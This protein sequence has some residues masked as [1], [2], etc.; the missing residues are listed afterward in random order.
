MI[1]VSRSVIAIATM[2]VIVIMVVMMYGIDTVIVMMLLVQSP[3][4]TKYHPF[5]NLFRSQAPSQRP[6][7]PNG[8]LGTAAGQ[9]ETSNS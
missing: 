4:C 2:I 3:K 6:Q 8:S 9:S 5:T 7:S 1:K